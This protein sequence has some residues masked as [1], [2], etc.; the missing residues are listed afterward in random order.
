MK[1]EPKAHCLLL[2]RMVR[3][4]SEKPVCYL[5]AVP[6]N[7]VENY[8]GK[9]TNLSLLRRYGFNVPNGF[10]ISGCYYRQ[11][12]DDNPDAKQLMNELDKVDDFEEILGIAAN[13]QAAIESSDMP[14]VMVQEIRSIF[15][16]IQVHT[17][18]KQMYAV[19]SSAS[20]E[21]CG[22]LSFAGQAE[23]Y[24]CVEKIDEILASVKNVWRSAIS[25]QSSIYLKTQGVQI[26]RIRMGVVVQ[27]MV[28]ADISGVLFTANVIDHS[29][30]QMLIESTWG[31]GEALVSGK[32]VPDTY[33][34]DRNTMTPIST[35]SGSKEITYIH[36]EG[37]TVR[38]ETPLSKREQLTLSPSD[39]RKIAELGLAIE[40][41]MR[42]P[43]DIEWSIKEDEIIVLQSRPITTL[44]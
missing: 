37:C 13:L 34:L 26:S 8:G 42:C 11:M 3:K 23:T 17:H 16:E 7:D 40:N 20:I 29:M 14:Q 6:P 38:T 5:D 31:L 28:D 2:N 25:P 22:A 32:V 1:K 39:L 41:K 10:A 21:D 27:E 30:D 19:R 33:I 12:I 9:A 15:S 4:L 36:G 44:K 24:L 43:Q 35:T 18:E